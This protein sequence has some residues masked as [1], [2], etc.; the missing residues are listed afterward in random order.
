MNR[1]DVV[2]ASFPHAAGSPAKRRPALIVQA[3][4]YNQRI[5]NVLLVPITSNLSRQSDAAHLFIDVATAAGRQSGLRQ[6]SLVSC[7]NVSVVPVSMI[8]PKIG[9]LPDDA[10]R[11]IDDCLKVVLGIR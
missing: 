8:G 4:Y 1:G 3:D 11:L 5:S 9:E 2:L 10:M 7:L 6:S